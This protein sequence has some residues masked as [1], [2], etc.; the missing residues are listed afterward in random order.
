MDTDI[1]LAPL[2]EVNDGDCLEVVLTGTLKAE[3]GGTTIAGVDYVLIRK[4]GR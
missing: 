3:F 4:K 1:D 2:E